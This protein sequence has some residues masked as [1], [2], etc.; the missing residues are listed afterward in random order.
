MTTEA[1]VRLLCPECSKNWR[2][3]P[4]ELPDHGT[5][6]SCPACHATRKLAEF[7]RTD[8]DLQTLK[9]LG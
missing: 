5:N 7:M 9:R 4:R 8:H 1:E 3:S 6:F 2:E